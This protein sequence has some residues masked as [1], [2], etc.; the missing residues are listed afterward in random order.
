MESTALI[1][2]GRRGAIQPVLGAAVRAGEQDPE[3]GAAAGGGPRPR[4]GRRGGWR[5]GPLGQAR[6]RPGG[7]GGPTRAALE[8]LE[9]RPRA[10]RPGSRG[11]RR[12]RTAAPTGRGPTRTQMGVPGSVW[13]AAL[14]SR[15]STIRSTLAASATTWMGC[16]RS[17]LTG[18]AVS[19]SRASETT[20]ATR[21]ARST[22]SRRSSTMPRS[23]LSRSSRPVRIR[24]SR[25]ALVASRA[26][27]TVSSGPSRPRPAAGSGRCRAPRPAGCAGRGRRPGGSR[28]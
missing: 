26:R 8:G 2:H 10:A 20:P 23:S 14:A 22:C 12:R 25:R 1:L 15:F 28:S 18:W 16:S 24:S 6:P 3:R 27:S 17:R 11:R 9:D 19:S 5:S 7:V 13:R 21:L 4:P